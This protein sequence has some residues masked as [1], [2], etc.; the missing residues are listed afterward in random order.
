MVRQWFANVGIPFKHTN[1]R[2][3]RRRLK[4]SG[5]AVLPAR[6]PH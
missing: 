6:L 5:K 4:A 2:A 3:V 1:S